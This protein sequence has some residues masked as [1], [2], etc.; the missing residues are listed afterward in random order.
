L[1]DDPSRRATLSAVFGIFAFLDVPLV[2]LSTRLWGQR[3]LHPKPVY[4]GDPGSGV[5]A[6]MT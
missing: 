6:S 3:G 2:Y 5:A 1:L 4:F